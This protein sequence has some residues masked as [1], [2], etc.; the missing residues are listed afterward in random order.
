MVV[1]HLGRTLKETRIK[2]GISISEVAK[3]LLIHE[4]YIEAIEDGMDDVLPSGTYKRIYT[5]A[6]CKFLG[7]EFKESIFDEQSETVEEQTPEDDEFA[8]LDKLNKQEEQNG[9]LSF[10]FNRAFRIFFK[11]IVIIILIYV[12]IKLITLIF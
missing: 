6:Y 3:E 10:D 8:E 7:V 1:L 9:E 2:R 4:D 5:R 11:T 12:I